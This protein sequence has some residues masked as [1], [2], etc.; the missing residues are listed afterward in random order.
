MYSYAYQ[1]SDYFLHIRL[2]I[3]SYKRYLKFVLPLPCVFETFEVGERLEL[4]IGGRERRSLVFPLPLPSV[5]TIFE[6]ENV[7][8]YTLEVG[9]VVP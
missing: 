8:N 9:N 4:Y 3:S 7:L 5:F 2:I 1:L 6:V